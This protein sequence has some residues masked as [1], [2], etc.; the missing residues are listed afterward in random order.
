MVPSSVGAVV[1]VRFPYSDLSLTKLIP[2]IVLA[3]AGRGDWLLCQ[4]T[5]VAYGD[6]PAVPISD[7]DFASGSL[8]RPSFVR[9]LR[10]FTASEDIIRAQVVELRHDRL[11]EIAAVL[12]GALPQPRPAS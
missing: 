7:A 10:P 1:L 4:V 2:A 11:V 3:S 5:S 6:R 12:A 9:P 8:L